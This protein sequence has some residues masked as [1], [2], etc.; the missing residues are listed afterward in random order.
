MD[1]CTMQLM[2]LSE[3]HL[4]Q[5][6]NRCH[7][8]TIKHSGNC[9]LFSTVPSGPFHTP[10]D[11]NRS[12][13]VTDKQQRGCHKRVQIRLVTAR[14]VTKC[15]HHLW[16]NLWCKPVRYLTCSWHDIK[17]LTVSPSETFGPSAGPDQC[18]NALC[19]RSKSASF[20]FANWLLFVSCCVTG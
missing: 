12:D 11:L 7:F 14:Q 18:Y 3:S 10:W 9:F 4:P 5:R 20:N 16:L 8:M 2:L 6:E 13:A 19:I 17:S 1:F 15:F